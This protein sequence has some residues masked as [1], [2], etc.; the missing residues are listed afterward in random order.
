[1]LLKSGLQVTEKH[2]T[3]LKQWGITDADILGVD[4]DEINAKIIE[5]FD[6]DILTACETEKRELF[7]HADMSH[8]LNQELFRLA[9]LR[10]IRR[11][12]GVVTND[13]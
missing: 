1:M 7:H 4:R 9:V 13:K 11:K 2:L 8:P 6:K 3:I 5:S 10:T 12:A